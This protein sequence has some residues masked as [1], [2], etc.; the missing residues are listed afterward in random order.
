M[1]RCTAVGVAF[2]NAQLYQ[3]TWRQKQYFEALVQNSPAA[4]VTIDIEGRGQT[5]NPAAERLFGYS[6]DAWPGW[7]WGH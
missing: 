7:F 2:Q 3:E 1:S 6:H 4:I 5:W